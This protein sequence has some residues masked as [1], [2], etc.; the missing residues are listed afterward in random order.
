M[1][2]VKRRMKEKPASFKMK[3][4]SREMPRR[5]IIELGIEIKAEILIKTGKLK[6]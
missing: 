5:K 3:M 1:E 6:I 4:K 2:T